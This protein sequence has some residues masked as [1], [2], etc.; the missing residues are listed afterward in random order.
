MTAMAGRTALLWIGLS[1]KYLKNDN[2]SIIMSNGPR[3]DDALLRISRPPL[4]CGIENPCQHS[5]YARTSIITFELPRV[6]AN[7]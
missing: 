4:R 2:Y 1:G 3:A 5:S 6:G 7:S